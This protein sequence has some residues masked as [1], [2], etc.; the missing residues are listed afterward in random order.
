[1]IP[2]SSRSRTSASMPLI[3]WVLIS[4]FGWNAQQNR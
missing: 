1:M 4:T 2:L 3:S